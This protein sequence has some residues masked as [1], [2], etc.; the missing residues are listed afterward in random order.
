LKKSDGLID[1]SRPAE[2]IR[3]QI[4]ALDPW[5]KCYTFWH[6]QDGPP[7]RLVVGPVTLVDP[8]T[9]GAPPGTVLEA[10]HS[11]LVVA[12]GAGAVIPRNIQPAGKRAVEIAEF[13]RGY[14]VRAGD[15]FG[16]EDL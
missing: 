15:R 4:R 6:R 7:L 8:P 14:H 2:T 12:A 13:L 11:R 9:A 1:W 3:N 16:P 5:P 10:G